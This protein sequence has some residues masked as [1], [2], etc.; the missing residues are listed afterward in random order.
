MSR[1]A[2][3]QRRRRET[4]PAYAQRQRELSLAAKRRRRG[5]CET[6]GGVT[7]YNGHTVAG[8]S[9][10]CANCNSQKN[11]DERHWTQATILRSFGRFLAET[12]RVPRAA[13]AMG[14][15]ESVVLR[16]SGRRIRELEEVQELGLVLPRPAAVRREF[17]SWSAALEA[18]GMPTSRGGSPDHRRR[19]DQIQRKAAA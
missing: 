8:A 15:M 7:R 16:Y 1:A 9:R 11:H 18:A 14:P 3:Y 5:V 6:C 10:I 2:E 12:G 4:D 13:D 17:G 19:R